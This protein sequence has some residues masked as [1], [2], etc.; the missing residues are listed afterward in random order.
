MSK[1]EQGVLFDQQPAL[2]HGDA[3]TD[4]E[5]AA[6]AAIAPKLGELRLLVLEDLRA[7]K[8]RGLTGDELCALHP[9]LPA[10]SLRPRLTELADPKLGPLITKTQA[11]RDNRRGNSEIVWI[12]L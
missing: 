7:A 8:G 12:A 2:A 1:L 6:A 11:R 9:E 3:G 5:R 10:Y 4:T